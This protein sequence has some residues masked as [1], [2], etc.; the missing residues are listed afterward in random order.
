MNS[1]SWSI[2]NCINICWQ[3]NWN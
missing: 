2:N 1:H 3:C